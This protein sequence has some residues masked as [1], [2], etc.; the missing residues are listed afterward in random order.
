MYLYYQHIFVIIYTLPASKS[1]EFECE[2]FN[3]CT[4]C[5]DSRKCDWYKDLN[6]CVIKEDEINECRIKV[7]D[8]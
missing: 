1:L 8:H 2:V 7:K 3:N 6:R 4:T 5:I